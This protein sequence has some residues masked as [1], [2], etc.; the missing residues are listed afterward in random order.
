M[1]IRWKFHVSV[2]EETELLKGTPPGC[3]L[4]VQ[5][6]FTL[7]QSCIAFS[8]TSHLTESAI[9]FFLVNFLFVNVHLEIVEGSW[10]FLAL[11]CPSMFG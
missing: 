3:I 1:Q 8:T 10:G 11:G 5:A 2:V 9:P 4:W 7:L 6:R